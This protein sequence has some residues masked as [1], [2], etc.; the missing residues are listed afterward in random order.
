MT[1]AMVT[2][3]PGKDVR[4]ALD[5]LN[6]LFFAGCVRQAKMVLAVSAK[7]VS[8]ANGHSACAKH[9]GE[10]SGREVHLVSREKV[11]D[12]SS[13]PPARSCNRGVAD[14]THGL[15]YV[16]RVERRPWHQAPAPRAPSGGT[17]IR[18]SRISVEGTEHFHGRS[19]HSVTVW[20]A[21]EGERSQ[22]LL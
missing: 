17:P 5:S 4:H 15:L 19:A 16:A 18:T 11:E 1:P 13:S 20:L 2:L 8:R 7:L 22:G 3:Q 6:D 12:P 14:R 21:L 10:L 9:A